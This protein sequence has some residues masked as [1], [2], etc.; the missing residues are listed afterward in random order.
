ML[1]PMSWVWRSLF[2]WDICLLRHLGHLSQA[3][4]HQLEV[5][6]P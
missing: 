6:I 2:Y 1:E 4:C 3:G 5:W